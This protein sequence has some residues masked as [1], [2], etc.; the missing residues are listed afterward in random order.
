MDS[1]N[2]QHM[3]N[4][5]HWLPFGVTLEPNVL[6]KTAEKGVPAIIPRGEGNAIVVA[7]G[8]AVID[9]T[10]GLLVPDLDVNLASVEQAM[11]QN[12][13]EVRFGEHLD[14]VFHMHGKSIPL[15]AGYSLNVRPLNSSEVKY[16]CKEHRCVTPDIITRSKAAGGPSSGKLSV[17]D[18]A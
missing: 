2:D 16:I 5:M 15:D 11:V 13:V 7:E 1:K 12:K 18:T 4:D 6:V 3:F 17:A 9:F 10:D 14:M 8:G